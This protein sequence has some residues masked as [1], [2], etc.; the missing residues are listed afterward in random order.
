MFSPVATTFDRSLEVREPE[1]LY[2]S[3]ACRACG[4]TSQQ[5]SQVKVI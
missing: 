4:V 2:L 3:V 1:E 5:I